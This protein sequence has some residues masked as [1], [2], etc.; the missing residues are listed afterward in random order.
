LSI[1][2]LDTKFDQASNTSND[3]EKAKNS[4]F[5]HILYQWVISGPAGQGMALSSLHAAFFMPFIAPYF[6]IACLE[7]SEQLG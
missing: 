5:F 7:Y 2:R 1:N 3:K 6:W 4:F